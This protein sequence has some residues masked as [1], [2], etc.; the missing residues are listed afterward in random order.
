MNFYIIN[1]KFTQPQ[2]LSISDDSIFLPTVTENLV[3]NLN[4]NKIQILNVLELIQNSYTTSSCKDSNKIFHA[5]NAGFLL[6]KENGGKLIAFNSSV[7]MSS[8]PR[9][10]SP[11]SGNIPKEDLYYSSTDDKQLSNMGIN[12]TNENISCDIFVSSDNFVVKII[13]FLSIYKLLHFLLIF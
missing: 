7:S 13:L 1:S 12:M 4:E 9:M 2:C 6:C 5:I 11:N 3:V 10:K 8:L